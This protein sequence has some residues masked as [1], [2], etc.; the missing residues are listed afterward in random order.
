MNETLADLL[1]PVAV[2]GTFTILLVLFTRTLT[3]Y[4]LKK[5]MVQSGLNPEE[6]KT[7]LKEREQ[8]KYTALKWGLIV[9]FGG[10]GLLII[11]FVPYEPSS[12]FPFGI[13]AIFLSAGFLVYY[14]MVK[15][16]N[17]PS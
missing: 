3:D 6:M 9:F 12:P 10:L 8:G 4:F 11:S 7:L 16:D 14:F 1:S 15:K 2:M 17:P 13:L 5:R